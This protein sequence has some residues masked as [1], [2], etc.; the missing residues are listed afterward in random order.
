MSPYQGF[1]E[2]IKTKDSSRIDSSATFFVS[3]EGRSQINS[4]KTKYFFELVFSNSKSN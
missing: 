4:T 2:M 3:V 1:E